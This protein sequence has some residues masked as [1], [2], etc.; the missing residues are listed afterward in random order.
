MTDQFLHDGAAETQL[1]QAEE[2]NK[3]SMSQADRDSAGIWILTRIAVFIAST[4]STWVLAGTRGQFAGTPA[5]SIPA[6]GP[7]ATWH[8]WDLDWYASIAQSGYGAAGFENNY[9]FSRDFQHC[10]GQVA[11]PACTRLSSGS[12]CPCLPVSLPPSPWAD[13][14]GHTESA[15]SGPSLPGQ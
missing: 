2:V 11:K 1:R 3:P 4:C 15:P 14:L 12:S 13:S 7:I 9:A 6:F 5:E 10:C 8:R